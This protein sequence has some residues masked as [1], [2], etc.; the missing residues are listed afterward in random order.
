MILIFQGNMIILQYWSSKIKWYSQDN[1]FGMQT[2][3]LGGQW[4]CGLGFYNKYDAEFLTE[5]TGKNESTRKNRRGLTHSWNVW[6]RLY[7]SH[8]HW[9]VK[10]EEATIW[11]CFTW[12]LFQKYIVNKKRSWLVGRANKIILTANWVV[13]HLIVVGRWGVAQVELVA[14]VQPVVVLQLL[15]HHH[16]C[17]DVWQQLHLPSLGVVLLTWN[18]L[19]CYFEERIWISR[20]SLG[21]VTE[22]HRMSHQMV[23]QNRLALTSYL[24]HILLHL[25]WLLFH[26]RY[27]STPLFKT[28]NPS[29]CH[30]EG[31]HHE[32]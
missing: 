5:I 23:L 31:L 13:K 22:C 4:A 24:L 11:Q 21:S 17:W 3:L 14:V 20:K 19:C 27:F 25:A 18:V 15:P 1:I 26:C 7:W 9:L 12:P 29:W 16:T 8:P 32:S 30:R 28:D 2:S 10:A 6:R